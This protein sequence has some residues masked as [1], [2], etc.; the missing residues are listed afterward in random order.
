MET[1]RRIRRSSRQTSWCRWSLVSM[2]TYTHTHTHTHTDKLIWKSRSD[3]NINNTQSVSR[4]RKKKEEKFKRKTRGGWSKSRLSGSWQRTAV[5]DQEARLSFLLRWAA[6]YTL[7]LSTEERDFFDL[8]NRPDVDI[9]IVLYLFIYLLSDTVREITRQGWLLARALLLPCKNV[10]VLLFHFPVRPSEP[11]K[12]KKK[13][14]RNY[15]AIE[16]FGGSL[17]SSSAPTHLPFSL[18]I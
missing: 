11:E 4:R 9:V 8:T 18:R 1:A 10:D 17:F 15:R 16:D 2:T 7:V 6:C 3:K 14:G 5:S 12:E 13:N